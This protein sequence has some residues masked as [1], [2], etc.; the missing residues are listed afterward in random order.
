MMRIGVFRMD[1]SEDAIRDKA[2][3]WRWRSGREGQGELGRQGN[4]QISHR[5]TPS[6]RN[7][8]P[9]CISP[10]HANDR[11][12]DVEDGMTAQPAHPTKNFRLV[13]VLSARSTSTSP[14]LHVEVEP[15]AKENGMTL[16]DDQEFSDPMSQN[17][18]LHLHLCSTS[19]QRRSS[20]GE[21]EGLS[22]IVYSSSTNVEVEE[23]EGTDM[24]G[25]DKDVDGQTSKGRLGPMAELTKKKNEDDPDGDGS[26]AATTTPEYKSI[27][28]P[29]LQN[30]PHTTSPGR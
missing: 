29:P 12:G 4:E 28:K 22:V 20:K 26:S 19:R 10:L 1:A 25:V 16:D 23:D 21:G 14:V 9:T 13:M 6:S 18:P 24:P 3:R 27:P 7:G 5:Q 15:D 17:P 8:R 30:L 11:E 2:R